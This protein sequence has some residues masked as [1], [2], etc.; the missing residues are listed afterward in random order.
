[1]N[2]L[3]L[4]K[5]K[6]KENNYEEFTKLKILGKISAGIPHYACEDLIDTIY[7]PNQF[8]KPNFEYF[9]LRI[10]G[11]SMNKMFDNDF[12]IIVRKTNSFINGDIVVAIIGD[13]ATC[14]EIKQVENYIYLIPHSTNPEYQIQKYKADQVMILGVVEQTIK[15]ILDK[16]DI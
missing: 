5:E 15:S 4:L 6:A 3:E 13:E 11:D 2:K 9:G 12:T 7:L 14:K 16:I 10:F 1:E 8:F